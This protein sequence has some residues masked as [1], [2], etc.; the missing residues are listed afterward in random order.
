MSKCLRISE[1]YAAYRCHALDQMK[2][3]PNISF[4]LS[5]VEGSHSFIISR[6]NSLLTWLWPCSIS[7]KCFKSSTFIA[8]SCE[9]Y[10]TKNKIT[11]TAW[12]RRSWVQSWPKANFFI[13]WILKSSAQSSNLVGSKL[14]YEPF[15][16]RNGDGLSYFK[17]ISQKKV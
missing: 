10:R 8:S 2:S 17:K 9:A 7:K 3:N 15:L 11:K 4:F 16:L 12:G 6:H 5:C 14:F 13:Q 1:N